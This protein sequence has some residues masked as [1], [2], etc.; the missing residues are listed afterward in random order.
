MVPLVRLIEPAG[1]GQAGA[2]P[3]PPEGGGE[4]VWLGVGE[5]VPPVPPVVTSTSSKPA[6]A[7]AVCS[8]MRPAE[9]TELVPVPTVAPSTRPVIDDPVTARLSVY[10]E[11][12][13][14]VREEVPSTVTL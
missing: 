8:P 3:P 13:D 9:A 4:V 5:G 1:E 10:Q 7:Y 14:T 12:T 2:V 11:P 6:L